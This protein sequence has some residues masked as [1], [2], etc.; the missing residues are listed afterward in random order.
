[1]SKIHAEHPYI[2]ATEDTHKKAGKRCLKHKIAWDIFFALLLL[3]LTGR[4]ALWASAAEETISEDIVANIA[5]ADAETS[6]PQSEE[7]SA[8]SLMPE[9]FEVS[10]NMIYPHEGVKKD[11]LRN[12]LKELL[13]A[14]SEKEAAIKIGA[15]MGSERKKST[16]YLGFYCRVALPY[17]NGGLDERARFLSWFLN[18][19]GGSGVVILSEEGIEKIMATGRKRGEFWRFVEEGNVPSD[20][21]DRI[22][23][24]SDAFYIPFTAGEVFILDIIGSD[25]GKA[26]LWKVLPGGINKKTWSAGT[27]E[28]EITVRGDKLY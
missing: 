24:S 27:W 5:S 2:L 28:R 18:G 9:I 14:G 19:Y 25:N 4:E 7:Y 8:N 12:S 23:G 13:A 20:K 10:L 17:V 15:V 22:Y 11:Q 21:L 1:M 16:A 26:A 3:L 6:Q